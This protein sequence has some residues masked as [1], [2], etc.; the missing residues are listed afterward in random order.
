L[1]KEITR[2][3]VKGHTIIEHETREVSKAYKAIS[4]RTPTNKIDQGITMEPLAPNTLEQNGSA[5]RSGGVIIPEELW[6]EAVETAG[7]L[8]NRTIQEELDKTS[9]ERTRLK[10][11]SVEADGWILVEI[12]IKQP[13]ERSL[14]LKVMTQ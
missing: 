1:P 11:I 6:P 12:K 10:W 5:E 9:K 14:I 3:V 2:A 4:K 7:Y 8:I 13:I